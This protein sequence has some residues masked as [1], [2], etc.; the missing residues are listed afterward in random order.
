MRL[1]EK[2]ILIIS[3]EF[4]GLNFVSKHHYAVTLAQRG[5]TVYFLN[6]PA[7]SFKIQPTQ[8]DNLYVVDYPSFFSGLRYLPYI[9]QQKIMRQKFDKLQQLAQCKF[10]V[11]WSFDNSVF[12]D[13][14]AL[15]GTILRISH[16]VDLNQDFQT[17]KAAKTADICFCTTDFI[18]QKLLL[19]NANTFKIHHGYTPG[20]V[21]NS[22]SL[23]LPGH[24]S[25]KA[26]Y[27]GNL[28]IPYIDWN[29]V[30]SIVKRNT[31]VDFIFIGPTGNSNISKAS[32]SLLDN[33]NI[34]KHK[35]TYFLG[36]VPYTEISGYLYLADVLL[37]IY[38]SDLYREQLASPHK[39]LDYLGVG[40]AI[41]ATYTDEYKDK[42]G[43]IEMVRRNEDFPRKFKEVCSNLS[44]YNSSNLVRRR[45]NFA[46]DNTYCRQI[47]RIEHLL[48]NNRRLNTK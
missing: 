4:W 21:I 39:V 28:T 36:S 34:E 16:I 23:E 42:P 5:N 7:T 41:V 11:V 19:Y 45:M 46:R 18:R 20:K 31:D 25:V 30:D 37:L 12:Y 6:P 9:I 15:P 1:S 48:E 40:K 10:D 33:Y 26:V 22:K 35:N 47:E 44:Y 38:Q 3:P 27:V 17:A 43:L 14:R 29:L 13:F 24:N 32:S 8:Y 2:K